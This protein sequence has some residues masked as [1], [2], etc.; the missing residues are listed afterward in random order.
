MP[1]LIY[2][3]AGLGSKSQN[4]AAGTLA[5]GPMDDETM[6]GSSPRVFHI[7]CNDLVDGVG[8]STSGATLT[9]YDPRGTITRKD[10][11]RVTLDAGRRW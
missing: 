7:A 2:V 1:G 9:K 6:V 5:H 8:G 11:Q 3:S 10:Q 4:N